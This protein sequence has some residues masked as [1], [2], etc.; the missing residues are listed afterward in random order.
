MIN[1]KILPHTVHAHA[2]FLHQTRPGEAHALAVNGHR[3]GGRK[4]LSR[5]VW[6]APYSGAFGAFPRCAK[7]KRR[8]TAHSRRFATSHPRSH[9]AETVVHRVGGGRSQPQAFARG[10]ALEPLE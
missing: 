8:N 3:A 6:S 10:L 7:P 5:S 2:V 9:H 4:R 1:D